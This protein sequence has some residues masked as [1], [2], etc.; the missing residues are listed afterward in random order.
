MELATQQAIL[1][2]IVKGENG[3]MLKTDLSPEKIT[4]LQG[5]VG[6]SL[7]C[8]FDFTRTEG[9]EE[10]TEEM[11]CGIFVEGNTFFLVERDMLANYDGT[12]VDADDNNILAGLQAL[13][14]IT[15]S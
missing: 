15:L 11:A 2:E 13:P 7:D 3:K 4:E 14:K 12:E 1:T 9:E 5:Y 8:R 10:V 6:Q